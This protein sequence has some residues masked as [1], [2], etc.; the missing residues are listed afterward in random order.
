MRRPRRR[1]SRFRQFLTIAEVDWADEWSVIE[2]LVDYSRVVAGG[3]R[4]FD[5][6]AARE[7]VRRDVARARDIAASE[8]H[9]VIADGEALRRPLSSIP[10][11]S[12]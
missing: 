8:N 7:L 10:V 3:E 11:P 6:A 4:A 5:E 12:W 1:R 9:G 2:Y